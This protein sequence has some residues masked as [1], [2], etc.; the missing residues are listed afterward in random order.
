MKVVRI[1]LLNLCW[2]ANSLNE[3]NWGL[4]TGVRH[5]RTHLIKAEPVGTARPAFRFR[6]EI[7]KRGAR[8]SR[9]TTSEM[10]SREWKAED[11]N[12]NFEFY[13]E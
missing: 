9:R 6:A 12:S 1:R 4:K 3:E 7:N 10:A 8:R 2:N 11:E 13:T 5:N